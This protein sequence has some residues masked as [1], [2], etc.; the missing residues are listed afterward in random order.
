MKAFRP[1]LHRAL[2]QRL[3]RQVQPAALGGVERDAV[4][5]PPASR[6]NGRP[7]RRARRSHSAVSMAAS[8]IEVSAPTVVACTRY[9]SSRHNP[10]TS[11]ASRPGSIGARCSSSRRATAEPP[12][13]MV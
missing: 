6:C 2:D 7:A 11:P 4:L 8:A 13:P 9:I 10:S 1:G 3:G 5:A 12:V